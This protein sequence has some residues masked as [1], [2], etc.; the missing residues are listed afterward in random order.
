MDIDKAHFLDCTNYI[1]ILSIPLTD[2]KPKQ[3]RII[4]KTEL[5]A[6]I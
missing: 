2:S 1:T 6:F 5:F 4:Y 3:N